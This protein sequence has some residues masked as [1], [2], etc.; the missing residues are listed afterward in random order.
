[1]P[2]AGGLGRS[3]ISIKKKKCFDHALQK[4]LDVLWHWSSNATIPMALGVY[5]SRSCHC[6][7]LH[8]AFPVNVHAQRAPQASRAS[9]EQGRA[10]FL[11]PE[12]QGW[13]PT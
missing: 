10:L 3:S 12:G 6:C 11:G 8:V 2:T 5:S 13:T 4:K 1:M 7:D 9:E